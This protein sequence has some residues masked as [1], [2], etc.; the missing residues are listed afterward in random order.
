MGS[1]RTI[2]SL[3][4]GEKLTIVHLLSSNLFEQPGIVNNILLMYYDK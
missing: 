1:G 4:H 2:S 3:K